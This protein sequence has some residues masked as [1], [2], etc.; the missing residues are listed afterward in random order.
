MQ[1]GSKVVALYFKRYITIKRSEMR[2]NGLNGIGM[3]I[4][5]HGM[6]IRREA[7]VLEHAEQWFMPK[8]RG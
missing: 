7:Y 5:T 8:M 4:L 3:S 2:I 6:K 1:D